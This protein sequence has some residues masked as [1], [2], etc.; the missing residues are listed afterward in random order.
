MLFFFVSCRA[1]SGGNVSNGDSGRR[2]VD[3]PV[4][5]DDVTDGG[6]NRKML[7]KGP[8]VIPSSQKVVWIYFCAK[9]KSYFLYMHIYIL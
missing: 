7:V 3:L 5:D 1:Q 6:S 2:N 4:C 8:Q 9:D